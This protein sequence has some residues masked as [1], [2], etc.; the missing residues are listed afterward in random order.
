[1]TTN[2]TR[3][4][5][6]GREPDDTAE[7][8]AIKLDSLLDAAGP[9]D[10]TDSWD[11]TDSWRLG[12]EQQRELER[13]AELG[14]LRSNLASMAESRGHLENSLRSLTMNLRDLEA[15]L[16]NKSSQSSTLERDLRVHATQLVELKKEL[17]AG[18]AQWSAG[19]AARAADQEA[20][21][22][23][24]LEHEERAA[25]L[26]RAQ[27]QLAEREREVGD[28]QMHIAMREEELG[29]LH[30]TA[31]QRGD[32][33]QQA[34]G[35]LEAS[36]ADLR[37][38]HDTVLAGANAL[39]SDLRD[40]LDAIRALNEQLGQLRGAHE[41]SVTDVKIAE[42]RIRAA[43]VELRNRDS[44]IEKLVASANEH[45]TRAENFARR[46]AERDGLIQRLEQ[47]AESSAAVLGKIQSN[48]ARLD[49]DESPLP[50]DLVARLLV[51]ND[52][53]TEIVQV[54]GRRTL[55]GRGVDCQL[56]IDA[57]FVSR[58]H[59]LVVVMP[60]ETVIEDL[61]STNGVYVNGTRISRHK[62]AEGDTVTVGKV[63]FRYVVKPVA[64]RGN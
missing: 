15:R 22:A 7:L 39:R 21:Q 43:D 44:R 17:E 9:P 47:E 53:N 35:A 10:T 28:L 52:G 26:E 42:E 5:A 41:Q 63:V 20:Q 11:S 64:D 31:R 30:E 51:R 3:E 19:E 12:P 18:R 16:L 24:L 55:I 36:Y 57:D 4:N 25:A 46:L 58:R 38:Q 62:L 8:P 27:V 54:L 13:E 1:M 40:Q 56:Q 61:N 6:A 29:V 59:A 32:T 45:K 23:M 34:L 50:R 33:L 49:K 2:N 14:T 60:D 48:L 37:A